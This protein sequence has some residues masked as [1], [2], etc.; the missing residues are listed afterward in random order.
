[1]TVRQP[2]RPLRA[3]RAHHVAAAAVALLVVIV[4]S[5]ALRPAAPGRFP[6]TGVGPRV[7]QRA[8]DLVLPD[9]AGHRRALTAWRGHPVAVAFL[10]T[11]CAGCRDEMPSLVRARRDLRRRGLVV[12]GVDAVGE[13]PA[14]VARFAHAYSVS[15]PILLDPSS[16]AMATFAVQALPTTVI[17]G[18]D[19][20]IIDHHEATIDE[21]TLRRAVAGIP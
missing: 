3:T 16:G 20:R 15:F 4:L 21:A 5:L 6:V 13:A 10:A 17:I 11:W 8:P 9:L 19:G 14:A 18:A 1:M 2:H 7:G 12:V